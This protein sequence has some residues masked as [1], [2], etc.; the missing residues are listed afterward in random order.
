MRA[1]T[2]GAPQELVSAAFV[3]FLRN[4]SLDSDAGNMAPPHLSKV[5]QGILEDRWPVSGL[6]NDFAVLLCSLTSVE[7]KTI[8]LR[9]GQAP[10]TGF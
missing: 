9:K 5:T 1:R 8:L 2:R 6:H 10:V 4:S 3:L 7:D